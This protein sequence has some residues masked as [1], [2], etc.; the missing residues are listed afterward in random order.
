MKRITITLL[1]AL[2][3]LSS[4]TM[5]AHAQ[6]YTSTVRTT[7]FVPFTAVG[8][9]GGLTVA[10]E[11]ITPP[12]SGFTLGT[13]TGFMLGGQLDY[14]FAPSWA[15]SVQALYDQKGASLTS[16]DAASAQTET[17]ELSLGYLEVPIL[18]K[19]SLGSSDFR[20]YLFAGPSIGFLL[21]AN[22]HQTVTQYGV[23]TTDQ[24][25]DETNTFNTIDASLLFGA[26]ASYQLSGGPQLMIDAGYALG[27]V[28]VEKNA[29]TGTAETIGS[30][31]IRISA[32]AMWPL[33]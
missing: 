10:G 12:F 25:A 20:P 4:I 5:T 30:R 7:P 22:T 13:R 28:N 21:S 27:L 2:L 24:T 6:R 32:A 26:G 29:N 8:V 23:V 11:D 15:L 33:Q 14:W 1:L 16:S 18:A 17:D 31:D 3:S 9:R 19:L